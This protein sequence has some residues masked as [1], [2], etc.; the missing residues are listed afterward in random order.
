MT[1][2]I[3]MYPKEKINYTKALFK[4]YHL[5]LYD[6]ITNVN[7]VKDLDSD[8]DLIDKN[9]NVLGRF[10]KKQFYLEILY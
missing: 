4:N 9:Q 1:V 2:K 10:N 3:Y 6:K 8:Y 7:I 5:G